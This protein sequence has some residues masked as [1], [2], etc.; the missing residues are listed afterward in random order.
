[1]SDHVDSASPLDVTVRGARSEMEDA[2]AA[3]DG[4]LLGEQAALLR[5]CRLALDDLLRQKP[6]MTGLHCGSTTLG[7]LRA[8]LYEYRPQA[9]FNGHTPNAEL[10][11]DFAAL[12]RRSLSN[13]GLC[14]LT[15]T[16]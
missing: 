9:I 13:D 1:M 11:G 2:I 8:S 3:V 4:V 10:T 12:S 6:M 5:E 16:E 14:G 7:N 15:T